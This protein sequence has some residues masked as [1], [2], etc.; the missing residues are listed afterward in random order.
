MRTRALERAVFFGLPAVVA[1]TVF[2]GLC[3]MTGTAWPWHHIV[4]EDGI[5]SLIGTLFYVEHATREIVPDA[6]LALAVAGAARHFFPPLDATNAVPMARAR[7]RFALLTAVTALTIVGGTWWLEGGVVILDSLAQAQTRDGAP[8][9][10]GAHWRYHLLARFAQIMLAFAAV[11]L[12]WMGKGRPGTPAGL[13]PDR[14]FAAAL[15]VFAGATIGYRVTSEPFSD[16]VFLGHQLRELFTHTLVTLPLAL[17][18]CLELA[19]AYSPGTASAKRTP[20]WPIVATG[21]VAILTG[22]FLLAAAVGAGAQSHGQTTGLARLLL[23]H[24]A[25]HAL[26]Y[27]FVPAL[28]GLLYLWPL[29]GNRPQ[30]STT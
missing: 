24:F 28:A 6:V 30:S 25:E 4:H 16:P 23:P 13:V 27:V 29:A 17:G 1:A 3:L 8:L 7:R 20:V 10:W 22:A 11:G 15:L 5:R 2:A 14:H 18:V 9:V 19:R 26:G 21:L 12:V